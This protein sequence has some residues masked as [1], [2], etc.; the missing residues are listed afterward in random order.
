MMVGDG[1]RGGPQGKECDDVP[2]PEKSSGKYGLEERR[3]VRPDRGVVV[4][5]TDV[6]LEV[7]LVLVDRFLSFGHGEPREEEERQPP[8]LF[9]PAKSAKS[10][11]F[12]GATCGVFSYPLHTFDQL[13]SAQR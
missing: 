11:R 8:R 6:P 13:A 7:Q 1:N 3:A 2:T 4:Q 5:S 9:A 10:S 12:I